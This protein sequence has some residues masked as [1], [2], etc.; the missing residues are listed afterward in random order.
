MIC[1]TYSTFQILGGKENKNVLISITKSFFFEDCSWSPTF[2]IYCQVWM[3]FSAHLSISFTLFKL[4]IAID[5]SYT[6]G[7]F[8]L[9]AFSPDYLINLDFSS[10]WVLI[11]FQLS[12]GVSSVI[13][14]EFSK[15]FS[16]LVELYIPEIHINIS[17]PMVETALIGNSFMRDMIWSCLESKS[18]KIDL[19]WLFSLKIFSNF[20]L[21]VLIKEIENKWV[22]L[23]FLIIIH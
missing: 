17:N 12:E 19:N 23:T 2:W 21:W 5:F 3:I 18:I 20:N 9:T 15:E 6:L 16:D 14:D 22:P 11:K 10:S 4:G 8:N 1:F 13:T 7:A